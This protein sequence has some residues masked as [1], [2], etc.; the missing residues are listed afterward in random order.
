MISDARSLT[1]PA[2]FYLGNRNKLLEQLPESCFVIVYAGYTVKVSSD[3]DYRYSVNRNFYYLTGIQQTGSVLLLRKSPEKTEH[4]LYIH[5]NDPTRERWN[6]KLMTPDEAQSISLID[7]IRW[8]PALEDKISDMLNQEDETFCI[9]YS[10][11]RQEMK[12][13]R[14]CIQDKAKNNKTIDISSYLTRMRMVKQSC[15]IQM[16]ENAIDLTGTALLATAN[17][18]R[19]PVSELSIY[20]KLDYEMA[21][22]GCLLPAFTTIVA[23]GENTL[24]LHYIDPDRRVLEKGVLIQVDIG[25]IAGG[26]SA[27]ISRVFPVGGRFSPRQ[28]QLYDIVRACQK[29]AFISIKPGVKLAD[30]NR[31]VAD[32]ATQLLT[33]AGVL[34][35]D[36]DISS[37]VW[38]NSAHHL[39]LDVHDV[40]YRYEPLC[41][42][43]VLAVEPGIYIPEWG[44][45]FRIEDD[46]VVTANGCR[47]LSSGIPADSDEIENI[48]LS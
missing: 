14:D 38:H 41:E 26:Y 34:I 18:M 7:N 8:L 17:E 32:L 6:G 42:N 40:S 2:D 15:E 36:Q 20:A 16:I 5:P 24:C 1:L 37:Y 21:K 12:A 31:E 45:G 47:L 30:I 27:D 33:D 4:A 46:V 39:G 10:D 23:G 44:F 22:Q 3:T 35:Q 48:I 25:G 28:K 13:L 29:K 9:D 43:N 19:A 11:C